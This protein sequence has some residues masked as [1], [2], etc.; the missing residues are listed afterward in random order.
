MTVLQFSFH[1]RV[2]IF[3]D[4]VFVILLSRIDIDSLMDA[5]VRHSTL[6]NKLYR[7]T[8]WIMLV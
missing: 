3:N 5:G 6:E 2:E 8:R 4:S 7:W 1:A